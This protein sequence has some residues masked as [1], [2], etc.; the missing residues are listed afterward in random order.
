M[1]VGIAADGSS[2]RLPGKHVYL[3]GIANNKM[4]LQLLFSDVYSLNWL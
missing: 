2:H 1:L 3:A 4:Q